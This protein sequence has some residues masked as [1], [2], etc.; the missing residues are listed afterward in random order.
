MAKRKK[1]IETNSTKTLTYIAWA[2]SLIALVLGALLLGYYFGYANA[3][4]E[5][6]KQEKIKYEK[7]LAL[8]KKVEE[9]TKETKLSVNERLKEVLKNEEQN[10]T[11][12]LKESITPPPV[13]EGASHEYD[14]IITEKPPIELARKPLITS[15]RPKLAIIIDDVSM[16][17]QV[18]AIKKLHLPLTMSFLPP[19]EARPDSAKLASQENFYMVHLPLEAQSYSKEEPF[20]LHAQD[21]QSMIDARIKELKKLFPKVAYINNHT[22]SKFTANETAMKRLIKTLKHENISFIDSRTT[23]KTQAPAVM[24]NLG[25]TYVARDVFLDHSTDTS[26]IKAQILEAIEIAKTHGTAIAIGHPH[27]NTLLAIDESKK[28][29]KEVDLVYINKLY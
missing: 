8:A 4:K 1:N 25:L 5:I 21:S 3:K 2:L 10:A 9:A 26:S 24:E 16:K 22:G 28:L 20:T 14:E 18:I 17:S 13:I 29:L 19:R 11:P 23:S 27:V 15:E 12:P 6:Q 7:K